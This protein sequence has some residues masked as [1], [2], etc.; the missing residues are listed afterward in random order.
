MDIKQAQIE[1][2]KAETH[3]CNVLNEFVRATGLTVTE[4]S[5]HTVDISGMM[6]SRPVHVIEAIRIEVRL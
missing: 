3:I 1:K 2:V 5:M 4:L 6:D